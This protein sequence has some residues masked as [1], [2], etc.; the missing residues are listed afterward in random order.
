MKKVRITCDATKTL[1]RVDER[2]DG[3]IT[4]HYKTQ[5]FVVEAIGSREQLEPVCP[6]CGL[7]FGLEVYPPGQSSLFQTIG[8]G[9]GAAFAL[10]LIPFVVFVF[11]VINFGSHLAWTV[12]AFVCGF[13]ALAVPFCLIAAVF[14][15]LNDM[16]RTTFR[17]F[18]LGPFPELYDEKG[19]FLGHG[20]PFVGTHSI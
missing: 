3:M 13:L 4:E 10:S 1:D 15:F 11:S 17:T 9:W 20:E 2:F 18:K 6:V 5:S 19:K 12:L 14:W 7:S 16:P 8:E